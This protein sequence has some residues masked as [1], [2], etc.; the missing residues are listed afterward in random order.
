MAENTSNNSAGVRVGCA[1]WSLPKEYSPLFPSE[2]THLTRYA[3]RFPAVE[4]N[5]SFYRP[6]LPAT[7]ARWGESVP[8]DFLFSV[9]LPKVITHERRLADVNDIL[10]RFLRETDHLDSKRGPLL[11]QLPPSLSFSAAPTKTFLAGLRERFDGPVAL[12]P[13]HASWFEAAADRLVTKYR[14]ARVAADPSVVAAASD[15]GGW[16]GLV[17]YRLHGSPKMYHSAYPPEY[18]EALSAKL[19]I[20]AK[21]AAVWCIFDNTADG[22]AT[23]N[24]LDLLNLVRTA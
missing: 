15:P 22:A 19:S 17:Y 12:E 8:G 1:G 16:A 24:A 4:I 18:L 13:R 14:V 9:K 23:A 10:N 20:L 2:G 6:H 7:Y 11:V 5:S 3:A 21:S